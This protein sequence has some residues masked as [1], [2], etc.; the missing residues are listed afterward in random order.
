MVLES[1][2]YGVIVDQLLFCFPRY[3]VF[4]CL[5]IISVHMHALNLIEL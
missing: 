1:Y 4:P 3:K 2:I 5:R